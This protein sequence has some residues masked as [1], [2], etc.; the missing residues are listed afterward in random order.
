MAAKKTAQA[1]MAAS[2]K[3]HMLHTRERMLH[4]MRE[5]R[6]SGASDHA[7]FREKISALAKQEQR[8][9][10]ARRI[11]AI[12][13]QAA[14]RAMMADKKRTLLAWDAV[15]ASDAVKANSAAL[16]G[17]LDAV[18]NQ[19]TSRLRQEMIQKEGIRGAMAVDR[20]VHKLTHIGFS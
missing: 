18:F 10:K 3:Q 8:D 15:D 6:D 14:H 16:G 7:V 12:E 13:N 11:R 1:E 9:A 17:P 2:I 20:L 5:E 19:E 4:E